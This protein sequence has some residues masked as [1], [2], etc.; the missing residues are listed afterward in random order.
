MEYLS[1]IKGIKQLQNLL[2]CSPTQIRSERNKTIY[3]IFHNQI[4]TQYEKMDTKTFESIIKALSKIY[5][6]KDIDIT[7]FETKIESFLKNVQNPVKQEIVKDVEESEKEVEEV[8]E[9]EK[10]PKSPKKKKVVS[11]PKKKVQKN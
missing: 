10:S 3:N 8:K 4:K 11:V 1:K 9:E 5:R 7:E 2:V 6:T